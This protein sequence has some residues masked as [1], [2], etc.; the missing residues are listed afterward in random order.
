ML[1]IV[2]L[3][4]I[5]VLTFISIIVGK[6]YISDTFVITIDNEALVEGNV[7]TFVV[8][9]TDVV[10]E[11]DALVGAIVIIIVIITI[12]GIIGIQ[13]LGSG[14]SPESVRI[15]ITATAYAGL[16][17]TLSV[18]ASGII[19]DI[20]LFGGVIYIGL[21]IV[22]VIGVLQKVSGVE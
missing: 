4:I 22:Y 15:I 9:S 1:I 11:V 20:E 7:S 19:F 6:D 3:F 18:L 21:T 2:P 17:G 5:I 10:F 12:A 14:L 8:E 16:W 13:V